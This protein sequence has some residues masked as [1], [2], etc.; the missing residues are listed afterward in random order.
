M[1]E[2]QQVTATGHRNAKRSLFYRVE[3][4]NGSKYRIWGEVPPDRRKRGKAGK[5]CEGVKV[6][7]REPCR[8]RIFIKQKRSKWTKAAVFVRYAVN[9]GVKCN[10]ANIG[11]FRR[12]AAGCVSY[13]WRQSFVL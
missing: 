6:E 7:K 1:R 5:R 2:L 12:F 4:L 11:D 10:G 8:W 9:C 13:L 3:L